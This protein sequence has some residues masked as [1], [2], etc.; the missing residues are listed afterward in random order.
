[1]RATLDSRGGVVKVCNETYK[2]NTKKGHVG[3]Q[4]Y[5]GGGSKIARGKRK[6]Q[7]TSIERGKCIF[8]RESY[9][10][11]S[12]CDLAAFIRPGKMIMGSDMKFSS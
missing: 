3:I 6:D 9:G 11:I 5:L 10:A 1:L 4:Q 7:T 12:I 8:G 2:T